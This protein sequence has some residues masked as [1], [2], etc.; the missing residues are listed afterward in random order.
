MFFVR[1][2]QILLLNNIH[3]Q[4]L[5]TWTLLLY[6]CLDS[7]AYTLPF[8]RPKTTQSGR[9]DSLTTGK[10]KTR[11][12]NGRLELCLFWTFWSLLFLS[13]SSLSLSLSLSIITMCFNL[14]FLLTFSVCHVY[15]AGFERCV[16]LQPKL[17]RRSP[18]TLD[19]SPSVLQSYH[20]ATPLPIFALRS[21]QTFY[22]R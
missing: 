7:H 3:T 20:G 9:T 8:H 1:L 15:R 21:A 5:S 16:F 17:S 10:K 11:G 4:K 18:L 12:R 6:S 19:K 22:A 13:G 14:T 2:N